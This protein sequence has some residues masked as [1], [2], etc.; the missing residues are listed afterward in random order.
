VDQGFLIIE[1]SSP[2]SDTPQSV[3][4]PLDEWSARCRYVYLTTHF[5]TERHLCPG[6]IQTHN[7]S[8][9]AA[10]DPRLRPRDHWDR[11]A[12]GFRKDKLCRNKSERF[13]V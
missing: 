3:E 11:L 10:A 6:G 2:H 12:G 4:T 8:K 1:D 5:T 7:P 13:I 9:Q